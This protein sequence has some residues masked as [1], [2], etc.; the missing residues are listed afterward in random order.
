MV[1]MTNDVEAGMN[2]RERRRWERLRLEGTVAVED[3]GRELGHILQV[4]GG[5]MGVKLNADRR[6]DEWPAGKKL[7]V[8]VTES[9]SKAEHTLMFRVRYLREG[10]LG[11]EFAS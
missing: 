5:G 7:R 6:I 1:A 8:K 3:G 4:S 10:V 9:E 2:E 11:L